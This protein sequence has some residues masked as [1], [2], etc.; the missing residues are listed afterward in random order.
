MT[1]QTKLSAEGSS[2]HLIVRCEV[3]EQARMMDGDDTSLVRSCDHHICSLRQGSDKSRGA[4]REEETEEMEGEEEENEKEEEEKR[5][6]RD[7]ERTRRRRRRSG[8]MIG[9]VY[10]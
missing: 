9:A 3:M 7:E 4:V 6:K 5:M 10:R 8:W 2:L 1:I